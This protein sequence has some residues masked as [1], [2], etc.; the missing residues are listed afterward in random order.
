MSPNRIDHE[1]ALLLVHHEQLCSLPQILV[2]NLE[3]SIVARVAQLVARVKYLLDNDYRLIYDQSQ[4]NSSRRVSAR[5]I[6]H[7]PISITANQVD[8]S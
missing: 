1:L 3:V 8:K 4:F 5:V 6:S 2:D 7:I